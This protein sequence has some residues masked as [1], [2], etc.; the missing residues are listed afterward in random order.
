MTLEEKI[1]QLFMAPACPKRG[2]DHE[3]DWRNLMEEFHI[4]G[5]IAKQSDPA[6]QVGLLNRLQG[7]SKLPLLVSADAEW[8]LAM[9]MSDTIAFP[10]NMTLGAIADSEPVYRMAREIGRQAKLVGVHLNLAPV[11]DVNNNRANPVIHMRSFG[12]DPMR[13]ATF[14][15]SYA[16][17]LQDEGIFACAKHF[18]GH[19]DTSVDSH[20]DLPFIPFDKTRLE[21]VEFAPFKQAI[22][23]GVEAIMTAHLLVPSLDPDYPASLSRRCLTD[24][25]RGELGFQGLIVSDALNMRAIAHRYSPEE[26]AYLARAAGSD[27]L[28]YGDHMDPNVDQIMREIIPRACRALK[29][30]YLM[31]DL[32]PS[33]LD[34]SVLRIL[35]AKERLGLHKNREALSG[36]LQTEEALSLKR[37]LFQKAVT[38][39]GS[40]LS[41]KSNC[42]YLSIG[43][44]DVLGSLF[45]DVFSISS[46]NR[47]DLS[48]KFDGFDQVVVGIHQA[49]LREK[50]FGFSSETLHLLDSLRHKSILC[51]FATPYALYLFDEH[52]SIL[53]G[54]EN[55][56]AAQIAVWE[57]LMEKKKA[58]GSLPIGIR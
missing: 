29:A 38:R 58:A 56:P 41:L 51:L 18:P 35:R 48:Q 52:P 20:V 4:G 8:G 34:A 27:I 45:S 2:E 31:G 23:D 21:Q 30:R 7:E 24:V 16:R 3:A 26:I 44:G 13:V 1:G 15:S 14:V 49:N 9:R 39:L 54:Y 6:S 28:L 37:E 25:L 42:A 32:D 17:G 50:N 36:N 53:V 40:S 22:A 19:G 5:A 10:R 11:A 12:E 57:A 47:G 46:D 43:E 55:D 33:E